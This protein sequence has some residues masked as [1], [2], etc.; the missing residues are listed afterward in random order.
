MSDIKFNYLKYFKFIMETNTSQIYSRDAQWGGKAS[1]GGS[2][3]KDEG[4]KSNNNN[5]WDQKG[6]CKVILTF[7]IFID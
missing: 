3:Y 5:V 6:S 7:N 2:A 1:T 4:R